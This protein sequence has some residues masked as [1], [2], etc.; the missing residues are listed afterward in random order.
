[1]FNGF[2]NL[3]ISQK[4]VLLT[5]VLTVLFAF[6]LLVNVVSRYNDYRA[7]VK[8]HNFS[9]ATSVLLDLVHHIQL[10]RGATTSFLGT[11]SEETKAKL[12]DQRRK[13][14]D[15]VSAVH[16]VT[17]K[18]RIALSEE[19]NAVLS[20]ISPLRSEISARQRTA[21]ESTKAYSAMIEK[22]LLYVSIEVQKRSRAAKNLELLA[23]A[24]AISSLA[25]GKEM[26]GQ[27][28]AYINGLIRA[29]KPFS[30]SSLVHIGGLTGRQAEY[31]NQYIHFVSDRL[32]ADAFDQYSKSA[33]FTVVA[34]LKEKVIA[35]SVAGKIEIVPAEWFGACTARI[36]GLKVLEASATKTFVDATGAVMRKSLHMMITSL[37]ILIVCLVVIGLVSIKVIAS[38]TKPLKDMQDAIRGIVDSGDFGAR[39]EV[40]SADE[41]GESGKA[42][43]TLLE[44]LQG[45]IADISRV[46][47]ALSSGDLGQQV[48]VDVKGDLLKVKIAINNT[49][50]TF[51]NTLN[52]INSVMSAIAEG[53]LMKR[54]TLQVS[55]DF[56][57]LKN[58][59]NDAAEALQS[60]FSDINQVMRSV[61]DRNLTEDVTVEVKG[62]LSQ[63][64]ESINSSLEALRSTMTVLANQ[65]QAV[66]SASTEASR[67]VESVSVGTQS[68]VESI[69]QISNAI[70]QTADS[71]MDVTKN[72]EQASQNSNT[73]TSMVNQSQAE[74]N[75][76]KEVMSA[77]AENSKKINKIT[78]VIGEIASQTN[79]LAL[80]AA[81][82]AARAGEHGKG[83]AVVAEEV[84]KL[85]EN[86]AN[87]V[88]E[89][90]EL[91]S[92]AVKEAGLGV[93]TTE[94]V[95]ENMNNV[96][97][98]VLQTDEI[99]QRIATAMEESSASMQEVSA[100]VATLRNISETNA[101]AS[102]EITA[103]V[104]E[105]AELAIK[106]K[107][108][109]ALFTI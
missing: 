22:T 55:G 7:G 47:S 18:E 90:T 32:Q 54:V 79:L 29:G 38:I 44:S 70:Q 15:L 92:Q 56:D 27:E 99:L 66:A 85:A 57:H 97:K 11:D 10:E 43:N 73:A 28:R 86:S 34:E 40:R 74:M 36:D 9:E 109:V 98:T 76:L 58:S 80:N 107:E 31:F 8:L 94:K 17:R 100:S 39:V 6:M 77:I 105:L 50:D 106:S 52:E 53:N 61:A 71:V 62:E 108:Q 59:I 35:Q 41:V 60:A 103:T 25:Y 24:E 30:A 69:E 83:F 12:A 19:M 95:S 13:V 5:G 33:Q 20:S 51:K 101:S 104:A 4:I 3:K 88:H 16:E 14:D 23:D 37:V 93:N 84:R 87:S 2:K 68:Q 102:E 1:M 64:K 91:V 82:E 42:L 78:E 89:I 48:Q 63:L 45:T 65:S 81:I 67:A 46:M 72:T 26:A 75:H 49:T 96:S 21:P